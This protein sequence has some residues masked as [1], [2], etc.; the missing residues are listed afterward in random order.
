[1]AASANALQQVLKFENLTEQYELYGRSNRPNPIYEMY[2]GA[3]MDAVMTEIREAQGEGSFVPPYPKA[4]GGIYETVDS[5]TFSYIQLNVVKTPVP[6]NTHN[7]M[8]KVVNLSDVSSKQGALFNVFNQIPLDNSLLACLRD[9]GTYTVQ[10]KGIGEIQRAQQEFGL[11]HAMLKQLIAIKI[12]RG[13]TIYLD[14]V[15]NILPSSSG[16]NRSLTWGVPA[17]NLTTVGGLID[18]WATT[19]TDII[20]NLD[21]VN[22]RAESLGA[23][24]IRHVW[25]NSADKF[26]VRN[27]QKLQ[28]NYNG[29]KPMDVELGASKI[30][31][32]NYVFHFWNG[33]FTYADG[34]TEAF[35]PQGYALL[36]PEPGPWFGMWLGKQVLCTDEKIIGLSEAQIA[37]GL[38]EVW[39][40][41]G[42]AQLMSNP[43]SLAM[44]LGSNFTFGLRDPNAVYY[45][46]H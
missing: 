31:L 25:M 35:I 17:G 33:T 11:R 43:H 1:M 10:R 9:P 40:D 32:E 14:P 22:V 3:Q 34:T 19:T 13:D 29:I 37:A 2:V 39:G 45:V 5:Q 21:Q 42:Y 38:V 18:D 26:I 7:A 27:N 23:P 36:T 28:L 16:A 4:G 12:M 24:P 6:V 30:E 15:G 44:F 46:T 41:Y 8:A 20:E